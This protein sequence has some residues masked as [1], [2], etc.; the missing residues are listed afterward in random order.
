[1]ACP[2]RAFGVLLVLVLVCLFCCTLSAPPRAIGCA[3]YPPHVLTRYNDLAYPLRTPD[4]AI[5]AIIQIIRGGALAG[6]VLCQRKKYPFKLAIPGGY[7]EYGESAERATIR[8]VQEET[9][10]VIFP[11]GETYHNNSLKQF[12]V[13]S[14]PDRDPRRHTVS[15]AFVVTVENQIPHAAD[16]AKSCD[17]Y[18]LGQMRSL[19]SDEFAFDH[20]HVL[21]TFLASL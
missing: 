10:I 1:M 12:H 21:Q 7:V 16:D 4:L 17:I 15:V 13:F 9:G 6:V 11:P 5:D 18:S 14:N 3:P 19:R 8:E 2:V 20:H